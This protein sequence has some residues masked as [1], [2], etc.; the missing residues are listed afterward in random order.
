MAGNFAPHAEQVF[1]WTD[2]WIL[3]DNGQIYDINNTTNSADKL[4]HMLVGV[5]V[6]LECAEVSQ[7]ARGCCARPGYLLI[8]PCT[9]REEIEFDVWIEISDGPWVM[10]LSLSMW[11]KAIHHILGTQKGWIRCWQQA[12]VCCPRELHYSIM[13]TC[14][15]SSG[16]ID[17]IGTRCRSAGVNDLICVPVLS[18]PI[19]FFV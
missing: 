2:I 19:S 8:G 18:H 3:L 1:I 10:N 13:Y 5:L 7:L 12:G 4:L 15:K 16:G 6:S 14:R 17:G 9:S 11:V